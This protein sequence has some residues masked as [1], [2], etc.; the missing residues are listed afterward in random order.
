MEYTS[1]S[2]TAR[3]ISKKGVYELNKAFIFLFVDMFT[4]PFSRQSGLY[5]SFPFGEFFRASN[6]SHR[7]L[8][9]GIFAVL[10]CF[11]FTSN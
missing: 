2:N 4:S 6:V 10:T 7:W 8:S 11:I 3:L 9:E 5:L 1:R